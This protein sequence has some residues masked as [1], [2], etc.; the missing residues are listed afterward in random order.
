MSYSSLGLY[1]A[2]LVH[3]LVLNLFKWSS[4]AQVY[5]YD[6][7]KCRLCSIADYNLPHMAG[8]SGCITWRVLVTVLSKI[9]PAIPADTFYNMVRSG[10][11]AE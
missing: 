2:L 10:D 1:S 11:S 7:E 8:V 6:P 4:L 9:V 5:T 3:V